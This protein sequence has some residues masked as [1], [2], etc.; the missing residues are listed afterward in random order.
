MTLVCGLSW[1]LVDVELVEAAGIENSVC[2]RK[3]IFV[4][5]NQ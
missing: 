4:F 3:F 1:T 5:N 2:I